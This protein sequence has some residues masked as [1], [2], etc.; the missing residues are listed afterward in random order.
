[1]TTTIDDD[2]SDNTLGGMIGE[3]VA[4]GAFVAGWIVVVAATQWL[5]VLHEAVPVTVQALSLAGLTALLMLMFQR[6]SGGHVNPL[7]T[8]A[9]G[10]AG[11]QRWRPAI[12]YSAAHILGAIGGVALTYAF[13]I[14]RPIFPVTDARVIA[15]FLGAAVVLCVVVAL[16][17]EAAIDAALATGA[18]VALVYWVSGGATLVNPAITLAQG[19]FG[20]GLTMAQAGPVIAAQFFGALTGYYAARLVWP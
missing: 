11:L 5:A 15:E 9:I 7:M 19:V 17:N 2:E 18:A 16:R 12:A 8:L 1:M 3:A 4:L 20:I 10:L 13:V 6:W 14:D